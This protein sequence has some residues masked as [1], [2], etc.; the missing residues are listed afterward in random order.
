MSHEIEELPIIWDIIHKRMA[1]G[2]RFVVF[3]GGSD[4]ESMGYLR[5]LQWDENYKEVIIDC[6]FHSKGS[7]SYIYEP[8]A[9]NTWKM[10]KTQYG[11][12]LYV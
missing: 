8:Q 6:G 5:N 12:D 9:L 2:E 11:W 3:P 1:K 10:K 4:G 7:R